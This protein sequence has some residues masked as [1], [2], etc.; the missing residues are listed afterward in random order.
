MV[1]SFFRTTTPAHPFF[2]NGVSARL[3]SHAILRFNETI[4]NLM[5]MKITIMNTTCGWV[6]LRSLYHIAFNSTAFLHTQKVSHNENPFLWMFTQKLFHLMLQPRAQECALRQL[7]WCMR[8]SERRKESEREGAI[9]KLLVRKIGARRKVNSPL[10]EEI[11]WVIV[12]LKG[13]LFPFIS[14]KMC[15]CAM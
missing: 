2:L 3:A 4:Q 10:D 6:H 9:V 11:S 13:I 8:S 1:N 15:V 7:Q 12:H 14:K 5:R